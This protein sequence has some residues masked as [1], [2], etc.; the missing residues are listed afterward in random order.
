MAYNY[1]NS[2][3][4]RTYTMQSV[5]QMN[6]SQPSLSSVSPPQASM[7]PGKIISRQE[8]I[9]PQDIPGNGA[10]GLFLM[11]DLSAIY[12]KQWVN[13]VPQTARYILDQP[14]PQS[15]GNE[16]VLKR[17]DNIEKMLKRKHRPYKPQK[18]EKNN[19]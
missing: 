16:E 7:L 14:A 1:Y 3:Q 12:A 11:N 2:P 8:D 10:I 15:S 6:N 17:L 4:D 5:P 9:L 13:G 18:E 19:D